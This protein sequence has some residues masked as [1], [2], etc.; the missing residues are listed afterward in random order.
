[1][2][3][4]VH[5]RCSFCLFEATCNQIALQCKSPCPKASWLI[6]KFIHIGGGQWHMARLHKPRANSVFS[7]PNLCI[8]RNQKK[9][10]LVSGRQQKCLTTFQTETV[11]KFCSAVATDKLKMLHKWINFWTQINWNADDWLHK[12]NNKQLPTQMNKSFLMPVWDWN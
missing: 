2:S 5:V 10:I 4:T 8:E 9:I 6:S 3:L 1:L 11:S 7:D 12:R